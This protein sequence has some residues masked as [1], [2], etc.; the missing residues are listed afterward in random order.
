MKK[1]FTLF[2]FAAV[3]MLINLKV[4]AQ[5]C[6]A[7][8]PMGGCS[9]TSSSS[10]LLGKGQFQASAGYRYFQ[11]FRH[12]KSDSE[13]KERLENHT[14]VIN[15]AHSLDLGLSYGVTNRLS[16]SANLPLIYYDRSSLYEHYGNSKTANPEQ[17]R[18]HTGAQGIGDM[19]LSA[20]YWLLDPAKHHNKNLAVGLGVKLP[21]GNENVQ[22]EFHRRKSSD[23]T[24][25]VIVKAVDQSIQLG[26]GG[27]GISL[28]LQGFTQIFDRGAFYF[29][30]FYM[31]NPRET[32]NTVNRVLNANSTSVDSITAFHSVADQFVARFGVNYGL[33]PKQGIAVGLGMRAEGIPSKDLIGGSKGF[34]RPGFIVSIEPGVA[35]QRGN[36]I[37]TANVPY[38]LYR[39]RTRSVA[40][41]AGGN[42]ANGIP[43]NG[44]AAFADYSVNVGV[45][46]RFG[47]QK[48]SHDDMGKLPKFN[49][50]NKK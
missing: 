10:I 30:G 5:G 7:I 35:V 47:G 21:T 29:N 48:M 4:N 33:L 43:R 18:F 45:A 46:Y 40:D 23:G 8:R 6:V 37:F 25:S 15:D 44:D 36:F 28:E 34:R 31:S 1:I 11:S 16:V 32:N 26:D 39:K 27:V 19:R 2:A 13:Q 14:E 42:D 17:M 12:F 50:V 9:G 20:A 41:I 24:D 3:L 22:D 38:A 49:D